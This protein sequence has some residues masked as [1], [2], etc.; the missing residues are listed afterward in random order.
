MQKL[1]QSIQ[2]NKTIV[3]FQEPHA[4]FSHGYLMLLFP[5]E[6]NEKFKSLSL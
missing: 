2:I 4:V 6:L 3:D 1:I 5:Y